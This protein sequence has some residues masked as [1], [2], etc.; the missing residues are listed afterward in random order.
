M[1]I[2]KAR[3]K[4][5]GVGIHFSQETQLQIKWAKAGVNIIMHS[6]DFALFRQRL[7]DDFT[8]IRL[9]LGEKVSTK[10]E[11]GDRSIL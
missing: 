10:G 11:E 8:E 5:L 2:S 4:E 3:E 9:A 1:I 7:K 6:S